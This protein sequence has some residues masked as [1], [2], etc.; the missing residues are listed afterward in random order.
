[1]SPAERVAGKIGTIIKGAAQVVALIPVPGAQP[2]D[3]AASGLS[4]INSLRATIRIPAMLI[5]APWIQRIIP[6][7]C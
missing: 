5:I 3:R 6:P 1:M 4:D 2:G 7:I